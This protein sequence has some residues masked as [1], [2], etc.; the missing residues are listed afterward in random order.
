V[1][2]GEPTDPGGKSFVEPELTPP[3][4][5]DEVAKPLVSKL[6]SND[7]RH[8]VSVT[9][10]GCFGIEKHSSSANFLISVHSSAVT[11][12]LTDR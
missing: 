6:V 7:V 4:H 10:R 11:I 5:G 8:P 12:P 9:V 2:N 3:V 1:V